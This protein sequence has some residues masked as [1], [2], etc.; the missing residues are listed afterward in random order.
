MTVAQKPQQRLIKKIS[1]IIV[2]LSNNL[3]NILSKLLFLPNR[4]EIFRCCPNNNLDAYLAT[5]IG[6]VEISRNL[7]IKSLTHFPTLYIYKFGKCVKLFIYK[8]L[9]ISALLF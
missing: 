7:H 9:P 3:K 8:F 6:R 2:K 4:S 5:I 1:K